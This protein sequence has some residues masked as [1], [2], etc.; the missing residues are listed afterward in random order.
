M[1]LLPS[2]ICESNTSLATKGALRQ[3]PMVLSPRVALGGLLSP[4]SLKTNPG[5]LFPA[6]AA[7]DINERN[8]PLFLSA[9]LILSRLHT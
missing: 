7:K 1:V 5:S 2:R 3:P 8:I 4:Y 6:R 9:L